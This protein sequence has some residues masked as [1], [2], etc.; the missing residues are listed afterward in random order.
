MR[1]IAEGIETEDQWRFLVD[2]GCSL[3]QGFYFS[4]PVPAA[5]ISRRLGRTAPRSIAGGG[6]AG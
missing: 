6:D 3:G 2:Q 4:K 1:I 5:E